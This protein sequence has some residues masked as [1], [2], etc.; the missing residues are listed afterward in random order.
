MTALT[1]NQVS[2]TFGGVR[3]V[4]DATFTIDNGDVFGLI[5]PNG[6]GKTTVVNLITGYFAPTTGT[7]EFEDRSV[8]G[9]APFRL[10]SRGLSRTF[11]NLQ[12]FDG[13]S[14]LD[15]VLIGRHLSFTGRRW[16]MW[17]KRRTEERAQHRAAFE[18]L[19]RLGLVDLAHE[20]VGELPYGVRRRVEI[21]R[22]LAVEPTMLLLDEPTAGMTRKE[23]DE[24]GEL[25]R[26]VNAEGVT[27]LLVD[28]NVRLVSNVCDRVAVMDWGAVIVEGTPAEI[29]DDQRVKDAYLGSGSHSSHSA[30]TDSVAIDEE[31][32][33]DAAG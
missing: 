7:I 33:A 32:N 17:S 9:E 24:I 15:N 13:E 21:A 8:I 27:V 23:S 10:A 29:W 2:K 1:L 6:A 20:D 30:V 11:Q 22:A 25:I 18:L 3:A 16:Q 28:H 12:L 14:V 19:E 5:G 31:Q 26:S 4:V